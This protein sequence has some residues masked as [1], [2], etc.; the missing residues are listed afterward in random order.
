M[1]ICREGGRVREWGGERVRMRRREGG[2]GGGE[3]RG[4]EVRGLERCTYV[5]KCKGLHLT[6][7]MS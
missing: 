7:L 2:V 5:Q 4:G 1:E 6:D 3:G